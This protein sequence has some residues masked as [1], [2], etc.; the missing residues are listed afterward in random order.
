ME[1]YISV[2]ILISF[3]RDGSK[4]NIITHTK[5]ANR[6]GSYF[7]QG[8]DMAKSDR[9]KKSPTSTWHRLLVKSSVSEFTPDYLRA[10][11]P[12]AL[13][14]VYWWFAAE[15]QRIYFSR[16][17]GD[18]WPWT[19]DEIIKNNRFTNPYRAS[20]RTSQFLIKNVIYDGVQEPQEVFFR[21]ILFRL[22]NSITTWQNLQFHLGCLSWKDFDIEHYNSVLTEILRNGTP[23][24]SPAYI[25]P[26]APKGYGQYARKHL[27]HLRLLWQMMQEELP[28]R[29]QSAK[30][31]RNVFD[32]LLTQPSIG[33]FLA[34]QLTIDINYSTITSFSENEFVVP[35]PGARRG[36][37][38]CFSDL[39][40]LD[41]S[42]I[43]AIL[44]ANQ[45]REF[46]RCELLFETLGGRE[47][48]LV[49][50]QNIFCEV[51]KYTRVSHPDS[52]RD[53]NP[54]RI[55]RRFFPG[56]DLPFPWFPPKWHVNILTDNKN[57]ET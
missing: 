31:M 25:I 39:G 55:K 46:S 57:N 16:L 50:C 37:T 14:D 53:G 49:D 19:S 15:R 13:L 29:I 20:D 9:G 48:Q 22:F 1:R 52:N 26:P 12:T 33:D 21:I 40:G 51:D 44:V 7:L 36:I 38:K 5:A 27:F 8:N 41:E 42:E 56:R 3:G 43:I 47:L 18:P 11:K 30:Y 23:I 2:H 28:L 17:R 32:L 24:Y 34:Y 35:G 54:S 45:R 4:L 6:K 10:A